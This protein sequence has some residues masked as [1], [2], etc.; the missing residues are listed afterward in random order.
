[1]CCLFFSLLQGNLESACSIYKE[2]LEVAAAEEKSHALPILYVHFSRLK[3]MVGGTCS[4]ALSI[5]VLTVLFNDL[6]FGSKILIIT[7]NKISK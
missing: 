7:D 4:S 6:K 3:Y 5:R 1:M 2:A